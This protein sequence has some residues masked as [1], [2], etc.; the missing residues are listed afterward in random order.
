MCEINIRAEI[1]KLDVKPGECL[2]VTFPEIDS[3]PP[4]DMFSAVLEEN[5]PKGVTWFYVIGEGLK[6]SVVKNAP[7]KNT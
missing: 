4:L 1:E 3:Q 6:F 2:I 7:E 5:L